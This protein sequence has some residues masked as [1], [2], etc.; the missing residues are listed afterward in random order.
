MRLTDFYVASPMCSSSRASLLTGRYPERHGLRQALV[1][2]DMVDGLDLH[3]TLLP[4]VLAECG[5]RTALSGKWHLG[6]QWDYLPQ[7]RGFDE[8]FGMLCAS[9]GYFHH[10]YHGQ[11][12]LWKG[13]KDG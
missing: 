1:E 9:S 13:E 10:S 12:D 4:E 6:M 11:P 5:Y 3:E 2:G 7:R 8:F